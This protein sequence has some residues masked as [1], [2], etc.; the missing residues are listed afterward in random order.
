MYIMDIVYIYYYMLYNMLYILH[1]IY[2]YI[3][4]SCTYSMEHFI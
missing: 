2:I 1:I 4:I 3:Y